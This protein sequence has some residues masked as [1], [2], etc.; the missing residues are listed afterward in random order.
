MVAAN[1][2]ST[3]SQELVDN[4]PLLMFD[5]K[6]GTDWQ[7]GVEG[8]GIGE[9]VSFSFGSSHKVRYMGFK[10][11]NWKNDKYYYGN[12]KPKT[13]TIT[14]GNF[15]G[16]IT[17]TGNKEEEWVR[18]DYLDSTDSMRITIDDVYEGTTWQDTCISEIEIYGE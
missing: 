5:G 11:G 18:L 1:A 8:Y 13:I 10:L 16:Q 14:S 3:I 7:E 4:S 15:S 17:F 12:S 6:D 9:S 2:T